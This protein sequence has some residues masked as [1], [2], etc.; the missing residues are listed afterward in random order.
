ML[1]RSPPQGFYATRIALRRVGAV[2]IVAF[3]AAVTI[4][5]VA[6]AFAINGAGLFLIAQE[7]MR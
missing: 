6:V 4:P 1:R 3:A 5:F 7:A 2:I